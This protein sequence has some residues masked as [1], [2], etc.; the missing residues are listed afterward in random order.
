MGSTCACYQRYIAATLEGQR[1]WRNS[2]MLAARNWQ[3][4][5]L[6]TVAGVECWQ[7]ACAVSIHG[8]VCADLACLP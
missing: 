5:A 2:M 3:A 1:L 8:H 7:N 6:C 4:Y